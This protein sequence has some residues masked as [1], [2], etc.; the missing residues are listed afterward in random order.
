VAASW[1]GEL[2]VVFIDR[3]VAVRRLS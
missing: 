3:A 2:D 1:S